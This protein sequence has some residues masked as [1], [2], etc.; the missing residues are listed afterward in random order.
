LRGKKEK[1]KG[2]KRGIF[3]GGWRFRF[4]GGTI[5]FGTDFMK[6][7]SDIPDADRI[8]KNERRVT[9]GGGEPDRRRMIISEGLNRLYSP[10]GERKEALVPADWPEGKGESSSQKKGGSV[11]PPLQK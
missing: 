10:T 2:R 6:E 1:G 11:F 8:Q 7:E 5:N 4:G 9:G 3:P